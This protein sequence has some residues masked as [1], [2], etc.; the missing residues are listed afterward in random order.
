MQDFS[1]TYVSDIQIK[2]PN[3]FKGMNLAGFDLILVN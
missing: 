1:Y 3:Y 2:E